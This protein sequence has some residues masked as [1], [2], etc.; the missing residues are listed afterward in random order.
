MPR[1]AFA[2]VLRRLRSPSLRFLFIFCAAALF[3]F[4]FEVIPWV[5]EHG[6][7][8]FITGLA[9]LAGGLIRLL[10]GW[11]DVTEAVIRHPGNGFAIK[12][13]NGCSGLEAVILLA[14]GVLA[15]PATWSERALG[16]MAGAAAIMML[17]VLRV[18]S[19]YY[20]GQY[21]R[22]WFDWAHLYAWD[23]LIMIDGPVSYTHLTLPTNREV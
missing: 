10:G 11:A 23:V 2:F 5:N 6:I 13:A 8:P 9:W 16:W 14:A 19:L 4:A 17:N 7:Q 15:F 12:I 20:I 3:G 22:E 21:S 18:M 1:L